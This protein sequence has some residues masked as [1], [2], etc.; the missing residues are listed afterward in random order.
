MPPTRPDRNELRDQ[1]GR[2]RGGS[3][4]R[5]GGF[6]QPLRFDLAAC[7]RLDEGG[8]EQ[9]ALQPD[10]RREGGC[11]HRA[12][13][14]Q[15]VPSPVG[16]LSLQRGDDRFE[17][18]L[19]PLEVLLQSL[20]R[21]PD[22]FVGNAELGLEPGHRAGLGIGDRGLR[23]GCP[24]GPLEGNSE[25]AASL[26]ENLGRG[27]ALDRD[28]RR[29]PRWRM[30]GVRAGWLQKSSG[31]RRGRR[32]RWW[33][34][35][36]GQRQDQAAVDSGRFASEGDRDASRGSAL[37]PPELPGTS[38]GLVVDEMGRPLSLPRCGLFAASLQNEGRQLRVEKIALPAI[39]RLDDILG[40]DAR[41]DLDLAGLAAHRDL[42]IVTE[43]LPVPAARVAGGE[44]FD[45]SA[46]DTDDPL[47]GLKD[48]G[49]ASEYPGII[50]ECHQEGFEK[51][52]PS[53]PIDPIEGGRI[54]LSEEAD[55]HSDLVENE[56]VRDQ[57]RARGQTLSQGPHTLDGLEGGI[58]VLP[59]HFLEGAGAE[60][61]MEPHMS[62]QVRYRLLQAGR[63]VDVPG[64]FA[65]A[66]R[67]GRNGVERAAVL[68]QKVCHGLARR[69]HALAGLLELLV[70]EPSD[71]GRDLLVGLRDLGIR[72]FPALV[73][74]RQ[75][76]A[77]ARRQGFQLQGG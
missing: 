8:R 56:N 27:V 33:S 54:D 30:R 62:E 21:F 20:G 70:D 19:A 71:R 73:F 65:A 35:A 37:I 40:G 15:F 53:K 69:S 61:E 31:A 58:C 76:D 38:G 64:D 72:V 16:R 43:R 49:V 55:Y 9:D 2:F 28:A 34:A 46:I 11:V 68:G 42:E 36:E 18:R 29:P 60:E 57:I 63:D 39:Q 12:F 41:Q 14:V 10:R 59:A 7:A 50:L 44:S 48:L 1:Q 66:D 13:T 3:S 75:V 24:C 4:E 45:E 67:D 32:R 5:P 22:R 6:E 51:A 74:Q 23:R 77:E 17:R 47:H 26:D 25:L 52:A